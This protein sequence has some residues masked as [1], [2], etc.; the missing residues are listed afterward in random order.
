MGQSAQVATDPGYY[1]Y[2]NM[3]LL[4]VIGG[5]FTAFTMFA[6]WWASNVNKQLSNLAQA[7]GL[8]I[9][10]VADMCSW[11][12]AHDKQD[13]ERHNDTIR[14]LDRNQKSIHDVRNQIS[15]LATQTTIQARRINKRQD[16]DDELDRRN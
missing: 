9:K 12:K 6:G 16:E 7:D 11:S 13:D 14:G 8:M 2:A 4:L 1:S 5:M 3:I 15:H 10:E